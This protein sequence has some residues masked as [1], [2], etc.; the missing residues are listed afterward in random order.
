VSDPTLVTL[1]HLGCARNLIDSELILARMAEEGLV[2]TAD[3]EEAGTVVLNTCSF[4]GPAQTESEAALESQ[5]ARKARGEVRHVIVAGCLVQRYR[6]ALRE[7]FPAVDLFAEI[8]DYSELARAIRRLVDGGRVPGYLEGPAQREAVREGSRLL[9][10][11]SSYAYLRISHGCD[12]SCSFCTIPSIRGPHRS[13]SIEALVSEAEELAGAGARELV[14]VAEDSTAWGRDL[15]LRLPDLVAALA[16]VDRLRWVRLMY[17]YPNDFPWELTRLLREH[18]KVATYLDLPI[19]HAATRVLRGMRRHGTG[20]QVRRL[21]DRLLEEVPGLTL[22]TTFLV[23]FPGET[24]DDFEELLELLR[25]YR[26][27]R[28]GAFV[29]SPEPGTE[30]YALEGRVPEGVARERYDRLL[31]L[32]D[33]ILEEEQRAWLGREVEVLIDEPPALDGLCTGRS[34]RDAPEVDLLTRVRTNDARPGDLLR[35][36]VEDLDSE[37]NHLCVPVIEGGGP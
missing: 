1:I 10:T 23:G 4:I 31:E 3:L 27:S 6:V 33:S 2:V 8:S 21:L 5:L 24:D 37:C 7:R 18:E 36:R 26:L 28:V 22:R 32:R 25:R 34:E 9:A 30:S 13:K 19:Q 11:P 12:H 14:L 29:Y 20:D 35:A 16:E 17:A 15:G